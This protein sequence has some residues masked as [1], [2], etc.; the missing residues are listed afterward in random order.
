M[1]V[2]EIKEV[3]DERPDLVELLTLGTRMSGSDTGSYGLSGRSGQT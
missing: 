3:L 1:T 2:Q